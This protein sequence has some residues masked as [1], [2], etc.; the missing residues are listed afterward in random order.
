MNRKLKIL[1]VVS[2]VSDDYGGP[3]IGA[4][5]LAEVLS[6]Q[7]HKVSIYGTK[8]D[9]KDTQE[10][11]IF[12]YK[13]YA[14]P[15]QRPYRYYYSPKLNTFLRKTIKKYD[16]VHIHGIWTFPT[17]IAS[18]L[19]RINNVPYIIRVCGMLDS[20][21][22]SQKKIKKII[23]F[24][25]IEKFNLKKASFIQ[26]STETEF[27][28]SFLQ[29]WD[30]YRLKFIPNILHFSNIEVNDKELNTRLIN[31][32]Y[33]LFFGRLCY[34]KGIDVLIKAF[35]CLN[36]D[37]LYKDIYLV[38]MGVDE[39]NYFKRL[40]KKM[41]HLGI[42]NKV[43]DVGMI[44]GKERFNIVKHALFLCL[45]SRQENFGLAIIETLACGI[46]V[47]VSKSIDIADII[48]VENIGKTSPIDSKDL[49]SIM[50]EM[51]DQNKERLE[52]GQKGKDFVNNIFNKDIVLSKYMDMYEKA[53]K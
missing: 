20:W 7:G 6:S 19:S 30:K 22:M 25:L 8:N 45:P 37:P 24:H 12:N 38:I 21:S 43:I 9:I 14:F 39:N 26:F 36:R 51:I 52:M 29:K 5:N 15:I 34:K 49:A 48:E 17:F 18:R 1:H 41:S 27:K 32:K 50:K 11:S 3:T 35:D 2:S 44:Y 53:L 16:I 31:K 42:W 4:K 40:R 46:P 13:I 47:I 10:I 33:I 28:K 23:Y